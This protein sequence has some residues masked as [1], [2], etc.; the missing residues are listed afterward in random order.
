MIEDIQA[1]EQ[2]ENKVERLEIFLKEGITRTIIVLVLMEYQTNV[3][4]VIPS[5]IG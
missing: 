3:L 4:F 1:R 2:E 5:C